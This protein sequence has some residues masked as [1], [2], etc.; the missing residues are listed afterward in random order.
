LNDQNAP[1]L[2]YNDLGYLPLAKNPHAATKDEVLAFPE[3]SQQD[4]ALG[5]RSPCL[6]TTVWGL[7]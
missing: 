4:G 3:T 5:D 1:V 6:A 7:D 2:G